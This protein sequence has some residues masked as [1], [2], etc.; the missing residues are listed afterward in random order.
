MRVWGSVPLYGSLCVSL[1]M[2][3]APPP[4]LSAT[5]TTTYHLPIEVGFLSIE[6]QRL[7]WR[8]S[9]SSAAI[10]DLLRI[11]QRSPTKEAA[12]KKKECMVELIP[13]DRPDVSLKS[14][15]KNYLLQSWHL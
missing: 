5:T 12:K 1:T 10:V 11:I 8:F 9:A 13:V 4:P 2:K 7:E 3:D 6:G 14:R 15:P